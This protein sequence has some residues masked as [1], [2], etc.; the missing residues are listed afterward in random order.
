MKKAFFKTLICSVLLFAG[1]CKKDQ[2]ATNNITQPTTL[3]NGLLD[4]SVENQ[5]FNTGINVN[6]V[7]IVIP[8]TA[9]ISALKVNFKLALNVI[10]TVNNNIVKPGDKVD[11]T[12]PVTLTLKTTDNKQTTSY[13]ITVQNQ[14]EYYG[15]GKHVVFEKSQ[16]KSFD[17]YIDQFDQSTFESINC[18]PTVTT[19]ALKWA[20]STYTLRPTDARNAIRAGGGWWFTSDIEEYLSKFGI[21]NATL[22][23]N[24]IDDDI[25]NIVDNGYIAIL[26]LDMFYVNFNINNQEHTNKFYV[27]QDAQWGHF[28]LVKGYK[29]VDGAFYVEI[30]DPYSKGQAYGFPEPPNQIK[31]KNRYYLAS[32]LKPAIDKWWPYVIA[33][34]PSGKDVV[35]T[36]VR[37]LKVNSLKNIP[38]ASGQ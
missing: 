25:K 17:Y 1:A 36:G 9:D 14:M 29:I 8:Y 24:N 30:Y 19:M 38:A 7:N 21:K 3:V 34:A 27:T 6:S 18:G 32:Y 20:D 12:N 4:F 26:C 2:P 16:N 15:L 28:L 5:F 11:F 31:G 23:L 22:P 37:T 10:A 33:V 35:L 13:T